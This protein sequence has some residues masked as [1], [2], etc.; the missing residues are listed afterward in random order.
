MK[1]MIF[2]FMSKLFLPLAPFFR[3]RV[4]VRITI[5][6]KERKWFKDNNKSFN[7]AEETV[8]Q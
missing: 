1:E 3:V 2:N 6:F 8:N 7:L 4:R 5:V